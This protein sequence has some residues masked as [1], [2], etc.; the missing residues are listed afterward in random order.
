MTSNYKELLQLFWSI[1]NLC[2]P[3]VVGPDVMGDVVDDIDTIFS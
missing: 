3:A 2:V 1:D